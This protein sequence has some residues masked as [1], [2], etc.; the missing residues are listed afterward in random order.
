MMHICIHIY[1]GRAR[2]ALPDDT[3]VGARP[4]MMIVVIISITTIIITIAI[5]FTIII[6]I[7]LTL[8]HTLTISSDA[9]LAALAAHRDGRFRLVCRRGVS[10]PDLCCACFSSLGLA[11][12]GAMPSFP[13]T[14]AAL[15]FRA[16]SNCL[17]APS[18]CRITGVDRCPYP[19]MRNHPRAHVHIRYQIYNAHTRALQH[20]STINITIRNSCNI[21]IITNYV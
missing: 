3:G 11:L 7:T 5:T 17:G 4:I 18:P 12:R 16:I 9:R 6:T 2:D 10:E 14:Y 1:T 15:M 21:T 8:T 20:A 13:C 19:C